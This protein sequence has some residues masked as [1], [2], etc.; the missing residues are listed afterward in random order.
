MPQ[1]KHLCVPAAA[2]E[3][4]LEGNEELGYNPLSTPPKGEICLRGPMIFSGY[5]KDKGKTDEAFGAPC[6]CCVPPA[7]PSPCS[8]EHGHSLASLW[9]AG[10]SWSQSPIKRSYQGNH[11]LIASFFMLGGILQDAHMVIKVSPGCLETFEKLKPFCDRALHRPAGA[12]AVPATDDNVTWAF[13][14]CNL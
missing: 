14:W 10:A 12:C 11:R 9:S 6:C 3:L 7:S 5:Y 4:R 2:V 13:A 1:L 8:H